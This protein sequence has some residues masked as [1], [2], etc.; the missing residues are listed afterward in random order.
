ML[1]S[2]VRYYSIHTSEAEIKRFDILEFPC[3][4]IAHFGKE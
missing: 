1:I 2:K 4:V 3:T